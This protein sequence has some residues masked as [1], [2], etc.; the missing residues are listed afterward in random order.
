M[1]TIR[2]GKKGT[3]KTVKKWKRKKN[4]YEIH[5]IKGQPI[6]IKK[7][8][9]VW[10]TQQWFIQTQEQNCCDKTQSERR[11]KKK[12]HAKKRQCR[13]CVCTFSP[14]TPIAHTKCGFFFAFSLQGVK[15]NYRWISIVFLPNWRAGRIWIDIAFQWNFNAFTK[16]ITKTRRTWYCKRWCVCQMKWKK[17]KIQLQWIWFQKWV[18]KKEPNENKNKIHSVGLSSVRTGATVLRL[19]AD[20]AELSNVCISNQNWIKSNQFDSA[21]AIHTCCFFYHYIRHTL[22]SLCARW[23]PHAAEREREGANE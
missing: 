4:H 5:H 18:K 9:K 20:E 7:K 14:S 2:E 10:S 22:P 11:T 19:S 12:C 17:T 3:K 6:F 8:S 13:M 16:R 21:N 23:Q 1:V 15:W